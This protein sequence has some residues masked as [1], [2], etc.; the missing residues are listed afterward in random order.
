MHAMILSALESPIQFRYVCFPP[1]SS[2]G[3][4]DFLGFFSTS[5]SSDMTLLFQNN[6]VESH[7]MPK[8]SQ[9]E[10]RVKAMAGE[11]NQPTS[12]DTTSESGKG[13]GKGRENPINIPL[14]NISPKLKE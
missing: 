8:L 6:E 3:L 2:N 4:S 11:R 7:Q 10:D 12:S 9:A 13:K 5:D 14:D 1:E